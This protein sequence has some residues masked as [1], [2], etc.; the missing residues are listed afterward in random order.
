MVSL[1][2]SRSGPKPVLCFR[3]STVQK[4]DPET[5]KMRLIKT[6]S[7]LIL[8]DIKAVETSNVVYPSLESD[9]CINF[10]SETLRGFL[11]GLIKRKGAQMKIASI[12]QAIMQ[13]ARPRVLLAPL[14]VGLG[15]QLHH[16]FA[17]RF[18]IDSLHHHGFCC[19]YHE[20]HRFERSAALSYGTDIPNF[21][22]QFVQYVADNVDHNIRAL[23]GNDTFHGMGMIAAITPGT[24]KISPVTRLK[25]S[26][27]DI[28]KVGQVPIAYHRG[29]SLGE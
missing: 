12:G 24:K 21:T 6:A 16:H 29:E 18:L 25:A 20:V 11:E 13:A 1:M 19:S 22:A 9:E 17:S 26:F 23:D 7:K 8:E 14:Q 3:T 15:V 2:W 5:D 27:S 28:A 4:A 10:L